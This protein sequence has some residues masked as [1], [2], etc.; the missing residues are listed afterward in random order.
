[1]ILKFSEYCKL[2]EGTQSIVSLSELLKYIEP[3]GWEYIRCGGDSVKFKKGKYTVKGNLKHGHSI[4]ANRM[5]DIKT[6]NY[7]KSFL[8]DDFYETGEMTL[9]KNIPWDKWN[10]KDPFKKELKDYDP[11]TGM[12][13][14]KEVVLNTGQRL[15][16][17]KIKKNIKDAN[18]LYKDSALWK[19]DNDSDDSAYII[20]STNNTGRVIYNTCRSSE[21]RRPIL[22]NWTSDYREKD[23]N[24]Y[25][26][27]DDMRTLDTKY[28]QVLSNGNLDKNEFLELRESKKIQNNC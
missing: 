2:N 6:I 17:E 5:V 12:K 13:R 16:N 4:D 15:N 3:G 19:I 26:G 14:E 25:F 1:M 20:T 28:Y 7:L 23:G 18:E 9:L 8:I 10:L 27:K 22:K 11:E 24:Y 21:D